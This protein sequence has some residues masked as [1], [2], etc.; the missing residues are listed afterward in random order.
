MLLLDIQE[1]PNVL[2]NILFNVNREDKTED[3]NL[4]SWA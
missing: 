2:L 1:M 3:K 4:K